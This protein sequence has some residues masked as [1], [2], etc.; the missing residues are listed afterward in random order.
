MKHVRLF[1]LLCCCL[2]GCDREE[3]LQERYADLIAELA[4]DEDMLAQQQA[5]RESE[6]II[7][8][9]TT[10]NDADIDALSINLARKDPAAST[11]NLRKAGFDE[12]ERLTHLLAE[13]VRLSFVNYKKRLATTAHLAKSERL[14]VLEMLDK[15]VPYMPGLPD[16]MFKEIVIKKILDDQNSEQ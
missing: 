1:A 8:R 12:P 13:S 2:F 3:S 7:F 10:L 16:D 6:I 14:S 9:S 15:E 5:S 4:T 11:I